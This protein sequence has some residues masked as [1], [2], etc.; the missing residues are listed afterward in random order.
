MVCPWRWAVLVSA[1]H[2]V[3]QIELTLGLS[4]W[5]TFHRVCF[6]FLAVCKTAK[7]IPYGFLSTMAFFLLIIQ[8]RFLWETK[9]LTFLAHF[10]PFHNVYIFKIFSNKTLRPSKN[11][12]NVIIHSYLLLNSVS[13]EGYFFNTILFQGVWVGG[14]E[15]KLHGTEM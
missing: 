2:S 9:I 14:A 6:I 3:L 4:Y 11:C 15:Y 8:K 13:S 10:L 1:T 5:S 7:N 12:S